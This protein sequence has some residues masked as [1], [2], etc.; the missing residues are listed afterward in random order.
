VGSLTFSAPGP[1]GRAARAPL[2]ER[3]SRSAAWARSPGQ[4]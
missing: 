3:A 4:S 2:A 1:A